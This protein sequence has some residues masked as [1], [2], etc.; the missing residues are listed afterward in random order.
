M[1]PYSSF[2]RTSE[3][4][5]LHPIARQQLLVAIIILEGEFDAKFPSRMFDLFEY[6]RCKIQVFGR[7]IELKIMHVQ[8]VLLI[9]V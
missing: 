1:V 8:G 4:I 2:G 9:I 7:E 5:V 6:P 3:R